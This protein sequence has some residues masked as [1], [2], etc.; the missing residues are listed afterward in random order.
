[1]AGAGESTNDVTGFWSG[2]S[3]SLF[4]TQLEST[5]EVIVSRSGIILIK[6]KARLST[7]PLH[8]SESHREEN[9]Y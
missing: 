4:G 7:E 6:D 9:R 5:A 2:H 8:D 3:F 1:M